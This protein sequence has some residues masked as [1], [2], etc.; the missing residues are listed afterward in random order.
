MPSFIKFGATS[1]SRQI[2]WNVHL[3]Y[4][5]YFYRKFFGNLYRK[6]YSHFKRL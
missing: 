5:I 2:W 4:F 6:K 1:A 3:A